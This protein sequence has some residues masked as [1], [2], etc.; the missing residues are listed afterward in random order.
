MVG[1]QKALT[2]LLLFIFRV[3]SLSGL[4]EA[5]SFSQECFR[6]NLCSYPSLGISSDLNE[7]TVFWKLLINPHLEPKKQPPPP[8]SL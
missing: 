3:L 6:A 4:A 5:D 2:E 8:A 7:C 1:R